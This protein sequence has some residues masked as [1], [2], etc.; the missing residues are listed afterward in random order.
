MAKSKKKW[1]S[2]DGLSKT[3]LE[4]LKLK[5][6]ITKLRSEM[7]EKH[8]SW[9]N[10]NLGILIPSIIGLLTLLTGYFTG[11]FNVE[12]KRLEIKKDLLVIDIDNFTA[13]KDSLNKKNIELAQVLKNTNSKL[14]LTEKEK[15]KILKEKEG[16][17]ADR[18]KE[19]ARFEMEKNSLALKEKELHNDLKKA[20]FN[21]QW[22]NFKADPNYIM[23]GNS[24]RDTIDQSIV[25][26]ED[27]I[28]TIIKTID[29]TKNL[30]LKGAS[31]FMLYTLTNDVSWKKKFFETGDKI[32]EKIA[33]SSAKP[34]WNYW[35]VYG[36]F[37]YGFS[38]HTSKKES[39]FILI[40]QQDK[41]EAIQKLINS[42]KK[43]PSH[44]SEVSS[45]LTS[46][47]YI[48]NSSY[49]TDDQISTSEFTKPE[50]FCFLIETIQK[51]PF[52]NENGFR[53]EGGRYLLERIAPISYVC[54]VA[55]LLSNPEYRNSAGDFYISELVGKTQLII[56]KNRDVF[57][58]GPTSTSQGSWESWAQQNQTIISLF[59]NLP[60]SCN[61]ESIKKLIGIGTNI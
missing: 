60:N 56:E 27:Y 17:I 1:E 55:G 32:C 34:Y 39:K 20:G 12:A 42:I 52:A 43:I 5:T 4:E 37:N 26:R 45:I 16:F 48:S 51:L 59:K 24:L 7:D 54:Y 21:V 14:E 15:E 58:S 9:F 6:E 41:I 19:K 50:N 8:K 10:K 18:L 3:E 28:K 29:T 2:L 47:S 13:K 22:N 33:S 23:I 25:F 44:S 40:T 49:Y 57:S 61:A 38:Y 53:N 36:S 11:F 30:S 46:L 31:Q 35:S